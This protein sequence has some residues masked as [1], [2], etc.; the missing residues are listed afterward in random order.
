MHWTSRYSRLLDGLSVCLP[1]C[2]QLPVCAHMDTSFVFFR[3]FC[4]SACLFVCL[5]GWMDM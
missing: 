2:V 5:D 3:P 1:A 4:L